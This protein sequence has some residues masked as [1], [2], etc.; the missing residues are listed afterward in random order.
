MIPALYFSQLQLN[1]ELVDNWWSALN[2][3]RYCIVRVPGETSASLPNC[4]YTH[5]LKREVI[6]LILISFS[7]SP[8]SPCL[9]SVSSSLS[10]LDLF[11]VRCARRLISKWSANWFALRLPGE[12]C[13]RYSYV[14][15]LVGMSYYNFTDKAPTNVAF[16]NLTKMKSLFDLTANRFLAIY[17]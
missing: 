11:V 10:G 8:P 17:S 16:H 2:N 14:C 7:P 4:C 3:L 9:P 5:Q 15:A 1:R 6:K 12:L 13:R